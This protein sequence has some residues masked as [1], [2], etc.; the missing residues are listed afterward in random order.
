M[1]PTQIIKKLESLIPFAKDVTWT[2]SDIRAYIDMNCP[3]A[4]PAE[5]QRI[6]NDFMDHYHDLDLAIM[7]YQYGRREKQWQRANNKH[8]YRVKM[9]NGGTKFVH[10]CE[11]QVKARCAS[12]VYG[13]T[14]EM[15]G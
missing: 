5:K 3:G 13:Q 4:T 7:R 6:R 2:E 12:G 1:L 9:L 15:V 8:Y 11:E 14:Y 10:M